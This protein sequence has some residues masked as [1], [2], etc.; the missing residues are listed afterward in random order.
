MITIKKILVPTDFSNISV[1]AIG[2]AISLAKDH[3]AEVIVLHAMSMK[4]V[5]A[6]F[7]PEGYIVQEILPTGT[8]VAPGPQIDLE[9]ILESKNQFL[10]N[11]LGQKIGPE[12]LATVQI[13]PVTRLGG[14]VQEIIATAKEEQCDLIV[15]TS[16]GRSLPRS[17]LA[18]SYTERVVRKAPCP[19]LSIQPSAKVRTENNERVSVR[20]MEQTGAAF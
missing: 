1:P 18:Y 13:T 3:C 7:P 15:M 20:L 11:F 14:V 19:V 16:R 6:S 9:S 5:R 17:L 8:P 4:Q 10:C 12:A 2:Y